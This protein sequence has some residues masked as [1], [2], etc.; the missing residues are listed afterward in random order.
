MLLQGI[1]RYFPSPD[2]F[3]CIGVDVSTGE[4]FVAKYNDGVS[5][6]MRVFKTIV[7]PFI[8]KYSL[9]KVC[10]GTLKPDSSSYNVNKDTEEKIGK[11][12]TL[13]GKEQMELKELRLLQSRGLGEVPGKAALGVINIRRKSC[14][15]PP[16]DRFRILILQ[17]VRHDKFAHVFTSCHNGISTLTTCSSQSCPLTLK[18]QPRVSFRQEKT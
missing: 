13:R 14:H 4:R 5:L 8:G 1:D 15:H 9:V 7:D 2:H 18:V 10:T 12:Y 11:V 6:S 17:P 3:E 16:V